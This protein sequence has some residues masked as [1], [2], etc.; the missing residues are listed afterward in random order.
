MKPDKLT[1][2][3]LLLMRLILATILLYN[4][5]QKLFGAF[6]GMGYEA[7]LSFFRS[8]VGAPE[9]L[10]WMAIISEF[11]GGIGIALG[12]LTRLAAFG[13]SCTMVVAIYSSRAE[14]KSTEFPGATLGLALGLLFIGAGAFSLDKALFGKA[15]GK[16]A[17]KPGQ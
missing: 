2:F 10:G 3:G 13:A 12:L 5:S 9:W 15:K 6:G 4:G 8:K 16:K 1:D 17:A 11:F 14:F 7:T